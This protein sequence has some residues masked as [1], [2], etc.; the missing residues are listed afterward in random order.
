[1][2]YKG[3]FFGKEKRVLSEVELLNRDYYRGRFASKNKDN[4]V[5]NNWEDKSLD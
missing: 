2:S 3:K 5:V 1:M 4:L